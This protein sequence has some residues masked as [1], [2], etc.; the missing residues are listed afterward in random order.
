MAH[1][2]ITNNPA[3]KTLRT[4]L[5]TLISIS[6]E[7]KWLV[8]FFYFSGWQ[9]VYEQLK[10]NR[11]ITLK[12]LIGLKVQKIIHSMIEHGDQDE[13]L[14]QD[15]VFQEFMTSLG[16]AINNDDM[17]SE[18]FYSQVE[19]FLEMMDEGRLMIRKTENPNHAKLYL[20]KYNEHHTEVH[21]RPGEFITGSSNLT[22]SGLSAQ[23]EFNVEIR[24]Y[25]FEDAEAYFDELWERAVRISEDPDRRK[26]LLDF[27]RHRSQAATVTPFEAYLLILK[28]YL[29][30]QQQKHIRPEVERILEENDFKKYSYQIDAVD[31]AL[32][33]IN[34]YH[35][36]IIADVVGLG[37]SV[38]AS[39]IAKNLGKR[40]LVICPPGLIGD[41][42]EGV[43]SPGWWGYIHKFRLWD[44]EVESR[45]ILSELA[46]NIHEKEI[47]VVI[48][49]EAHYYRNQ[50]TDDYEALQT[51]CRDKIVIL[52][53]ATPFNNSPNDIFSLLKLFLVPGKSGITLEDNLEA[54]FRSYNYRF[55]KLSYITKN[56]NSADPEKIKKAEDLYKLFVDDRLPIDLHKVREHTRN[57]AN[58]IKSV[59]SPVVIRRNRLDLKSDHVYSQEVKDLSEVADPKEMFFYLSPEQSAFYDRI[60]NAYFI[61]GGR[62]TGA[63]YQPFSYESEF[64]DEDTLDEEGNRAYQ[65]QRNLYDFMRRLLVKRFESS[66]GAFA[67]SID[68]FLHVHEIVQQ[69]IQNSDGRYILD[70][71]LM[72]S[73]YEYSEDEMNDVLRRFEEDMLNKRVPKNNR[74]YNVNSFV[75][76]NEFIRDIENDKQLFAAIRAELKQLNMVA[77]DPKRDTLIEEI[78]RLRSQDESGRKIIIFTE[79]VDT[80]VHL[81]DALLEAFDNR[82]LVC[83]GKITKELSHALSHEFDA[84]QKKYQSNHFDILLTSDKLSEGFNLN[85][86]G[87]IINYD[88]PWNPTRVIQ[89]VGRINRIGTKVYDEL[90]IYN[91]FPSEAGSDVVKSR[92]IATQKM[93]LIH[94]ALGEDAKIFDAEEEPTASGL[95]AKLHQNPE[96]FEE[97]N[98]TTIVRNTFN[99]LATAHPEIIDKI[100]HLPPRVKSAKAFD[101]HIV[102]VLRRKGL[103]LFSHLVP[104]SDGSELKV[105]ETL[106]EDFLPYVACPFEEP[107]LSLSKAFWPA[108][109]IAKTYKPE[110]KTG[111]RI[112]PLESRAMDALKVGLKLCN[113]NDSEMLAFIKTLVTDIRKY[114]TLSAR[115]L[116]RIGR[117]N[118]NLTSTDKE[119]KAFFEEIRWIRSHLGADYLEK[120]LERVKD[121]RDEVIIAVEDQNNK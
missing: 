56:A 106:F 93:F 87:V 120:I 67:K 7:L 4:R 48:V 63:I 100:S 47:D 109:E 41:R 23:E 73:I 110:Y 37:K 35:G 52:L 50:D 121:L 28:T 6:D 84:Q 24:D 57:L 74:V 5:N 91:Y 99:E 70:R 31:Q 8:G 20:F 18:A 119:I 39:L 45:G 98:L 105:E 78:Q 51:I 94:N 107:K 43:N 80:V 118:L 13:G 96:S 19:F 79:Y 25:G 46:E 33:I 101:S 89:R 17:D 66:F 44:W 85:R 102:T 77:Q 111:R 104:I 108:Y 54:V 15:D 16:Y 12:L 10:S 59:I 36:V 81:S 58:Q 88:I 22:H 32:S 9:E 3:Q 115:T 68:R 26:Y 112:N 30:L 1:N 116:G 53:T 117:K 11:S 62:F 92:E 95:F 29:D 82:V 2:F 61:E 27:I 38:I 21:A 113:P 42:V 83:D 114:Q 86:A 103:G 40:G 49:D 14:S 76:A 90:H 71:K 69:F 60:I 55:T 72:E 97:L 65:Q 64:E 34:E 75:R